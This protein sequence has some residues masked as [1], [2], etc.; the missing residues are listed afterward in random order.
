M[1]RNQRRLRRAAL[2]SGGETVK[3]HREYDKSC[4]N[5]RP[6]STSYVGRDIPVGSQPRKSTRPKVVG[7]NGRDHQS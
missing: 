1:N 6:T 5:G 3:M 2:K 7:R 4:D